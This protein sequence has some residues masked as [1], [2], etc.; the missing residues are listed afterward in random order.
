MVR[1]QNHPTHFG[2]HRHLYWVAF[3]ILFNLS[4]PLSANDEDPS[5]ISDVTGLPPG[6]ENTQKESDSPPSP[7]ESR[8]S[9]QLPDGFR[10]TVFASEPEVFQPIAM[11]FDDR[12]RLWVIECF[13]YPGAEFQ[14]K[15]RILIF[16]DSDQDGHFDDRKIFAEG[17]TNWTGLA[18]GFGGCW[19]TAAP[20]LL[21]IPD[22]DGD[23]IPDGESEVV[24]D[25]FSLMAGHNF[26]NGLMWGPDGWLYGRHGILS[27]SYPGI[28]DI[29]REDRPAINC[30][31]W[32]IH[33]I[34]RSFEIV[35]HGTTNPWGMD[36]DEFG[37]MFF[38]NSVIDH[39]FHV[40]P[41]GRYKR[42]FGNDFDDQVYE[43]ME[44]ASDHFHWTGEKWQNARGGEK[45]DLLGGGH[46]HSGGMIYLGDNWPD[47]YRGQFFADNFHGNR[48]IRE[49]LVRHNSGYQARH[50]PD[51][52]RSSDAWF[53]IIDL[54]YGP[55]GSVYLI[56]WCDLGECHDYDGSHKSSGR[57][58][59]I[60]WK[61]PLTIQNLSLQDWP[62]RA[63]V[64]AHRH[65][66]EWFVRHAR[67]LL[68]ESAVDQINAGEIEN[69]LIN[70]LEQTGT[71]GDATAEI[72]FLHTLKACGLLEPDL[73]SSR[74]LE[75][76]DERIRFQGYRWLTESNLMATDIHELFRMKLAT[77]SLTPMDVLGM[78]SAL[79]TWKAVPNLPEDIVESLISRADPDDH[80][81][82]VMIWMAIKPTISQK[83]ATAL[84]WLQSTPSPK[85]RQWITRLVTAAPVKN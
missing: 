71:E 57:I 11:S 64:E 75:H 25:G 50:L 61:D 69:L 23:D 36:Y 37:Q 22:A 47:E 18:L 73:I 41:G 77:E 39:L 62:T 33:P 8:G 42:M 63:L 21:F 26:V 53:R 28:P 2:F 52:L 80:N 68:Q 15:D 24:L 5:V 20:E 70:A 72:K 19:V 45:H 56:D 3:L 65:K 13:S 59:R 44:A 6:I 74:M 35:C 4:G 30:G 55:D 54:K 49:K 29:P 51:F 78:A 17:G 60:T 27:T 1:M 31:I 32:R 58:Y 83:R 79:V 14:N 10:V 9:I 84:K 76:Q 46:A 67:R 40:I 66:N 12:G 43:L 16:T 48:I 34:H 7:E 38:S 82:N 81:L 85:L